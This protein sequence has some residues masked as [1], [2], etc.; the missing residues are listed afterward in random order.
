MRPTRVDLGKKQTVRRNSETLCQ[1]GTQR[2]GLKGLQ[3]TG[4]NRNYWFT[5]H[6]LLLSR[7]VRLTAEQDGVP[8]GHSTT[9]SVMYR[10]ATLTLAQVC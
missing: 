10:Q 7:P 5:F 9:T 3:V 4:L 2:D 1:H 8:T 6:K